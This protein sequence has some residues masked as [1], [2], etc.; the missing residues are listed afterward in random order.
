MLID[1]P[2]ISVLWFKR[3]FRLQDHLPL[4]KS[5]E[6][7][8]PILFLC[9]LE[10]GLSVQPDYDYRHRQFIL[11]SIEDLNTQLAAFKTKF[12]ILNT[13]VIEAFELIQ[14]HFTIRHVFSHEET[15]IQWTYDRDKDCK[16]YF[17]EKNI[18]W[19]ESQ[20]NGIIRKLKTIEGWDGAWI[21]TMLSPPI[22]VDWE[23]FQGVNDDHSLF[24]SCYQ[25]QPTTSLFQKGGEK[26]AQ[27]RL[28]EF[29]QQ[30]LEQ[31]LGSISSPSKATLYGSRLS[32]H[33]A[34]GNLSIRQIYQASELRKKQ[35]QK[36][37]SLQQFQSRLKWHCHFSQKFERQI[38]IETKSMNSA[39]DNLRQGQN[40]D[41]F[42]AWKK[43]ETG[44]PLVDAAMR[45][46]QHTGF[47][48]FR[49]RSTVVSFLTHHLWQPWQPGA[50]YL[51]RQ[52]LDYQP[53]I[54]YPQFQM[55]AATTGIHTIRVYNPVKQSMEK[56]QEGEFIKKW[57][58]ELANL[59]IHFIHTPWEM[60]EMDKILFNFKLGRNY[61]HRIVDHEA[62][63]KNASKKLWEVKNSS[64]SIYE[65]KKILSTHIKSRHSR[66][67]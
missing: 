23:Q 28:D 39:F 29:T 34:W 58:P 42:K 41:Y 37:I 16:A 49:L 4:Q 63:A 46:V 13:E 44:Y 47:L 11:Q 8:F 7:G 26:I 45:C 1:K 38:S 19:D 40:R 12:L 22:E 53:G 48:N 57:I 17:G 50:R 51:A 60:T 25:Y 5:I 61:P 64:K 20:S 15:G 62:T 66:R 31:Y 9:V 3:D 18:F 14:Q 24:K 27:T 36:K 56:D 65:S 6:A 30:Y 21:K 67:R 35:I 43:G 2:N 10:P 32:P 55:Q 33:I 54:H 59:P 52:F